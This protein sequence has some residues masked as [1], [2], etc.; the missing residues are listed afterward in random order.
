M[1]VVTLRLRALYGLA[2]AGSLAVGFA[3]ARPGLPRPPMLIPTVTF[4]LLVTAAAVA[5]GHVIFRL[6]RQGLLSARARD[7]S[8]LELLDLNKTLARRV[9]HQTRDLSKLAA[10]LESAREDERSRIARELHDELGQELTALRYTLTFLRQRFERD[11]AS[12]RVNLDELELLLARTA[13]TTRQIVSDLR[14]RI[15]DELGLDA[16]VEWLLK[17]A[18]ERAGLS[19]R[20]L[21]SAR[22][23]DWTWRSPSPRSVSSRSPSPTW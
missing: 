4:L 18:E 19:C 11:P 22:K 10:H 7:R 15:L 1:P 8:A 17:R 9:R 13:T 5:A 12:V 20:L 14:P 23:L 16:G 3:V 2:Y 6:V 21:T